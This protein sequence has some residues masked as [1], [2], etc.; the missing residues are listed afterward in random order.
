MRAW[1]AAA[2]AATLLILWLLEACIHTPIAQPDRPRAWTLPI[3]A[4][5]GDRFCVYNEPSALLMPDENGLHCTYVLSV[6]KFV[7]GLREAH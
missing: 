4:S 3:E 1:N 5:P 2:L 6:R 7:A